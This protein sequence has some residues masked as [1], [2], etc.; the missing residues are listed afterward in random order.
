MEA[1][2]EWTTPEVV[3]LNI[4]DVTQIGPNPGGDGAEIS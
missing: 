1:K 3:I 2:K 4:D